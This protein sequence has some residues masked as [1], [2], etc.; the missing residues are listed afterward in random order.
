[1]HI[2]YLNVELSYYGTIGT[3][4]DS[5]SV[6][7]CVGGATC[8]GDQGALLMHGWDCGHTDWGCEGYGLSSN[9][10]LTGPLG[11]TQTPIGV[12]CS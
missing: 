4:G 1:M 12:A 8:Y 2:C 11:C 3:S 9:G 10:V 5:L 7:G 6:W